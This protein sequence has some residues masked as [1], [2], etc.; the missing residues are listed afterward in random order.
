MRRP[1]TLR[2]KPPR[3]DQQVLVALLKAQADFAILK[4]QGWYRIPVTHVPAR[5]PPTYLAFYQPRAFG[6]DGFRIRYFGRVAAIDV[7]ARR[8][9]FPNEFESPLSDKLYYRINVPELEERMEPILSNIPRRLIFVPTTWKKFEAAREINDIFDESPLEDALWRRLQ[10]AEI[11]A[12]RQWDVKTQECWYQLDFAV[13]CQKGKI[14]IEADGDTWHSGPERIEKDNE[15]NNMLGSQGWSVL[16]FNG[17]QIREQKA[18]YCLGQ[19]EDTINSLGGLS[20]E[21]LVPRKFYPDAGGAQQ[22]GMFERQAEYTAEDD[23]ELD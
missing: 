1:G 21:G 3:A 19:I 13:F 14:D 6:E 7:V 11:A 15:R 22:M 18:Q 20:A 8:E 23:E 9:L 12:E 4:E 2:S 10:S 5:W 16:R 17:K